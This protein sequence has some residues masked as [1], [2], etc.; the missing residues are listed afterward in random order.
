MCY[1]FPMLIALSILS[2]GLLAFIVFLAFSPKSSSLLKRTALVALGLIGIAIVICSILLIRGPGRDQGEIVIP[3]FDEAAPQP[4]VGSGLPVVVVFIAIFLVVLAL[5][6]GIAFRKEHKKKGPAKKTVKPQKSA[7][8][9]FG[10]E[11]GNKQG[12]PEDD[13]SFDIEEK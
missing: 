2:L 3:A 5:I 9:N 11:F 1:T 4:V 10:F 6:V 12:K 8:N 7:D 13:E